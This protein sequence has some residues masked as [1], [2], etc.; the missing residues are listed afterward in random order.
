MRTT[1]AHKNPGGFAI[2]EM[3]SIYADS[4]L[5]RKYFRML[6]ALIL[7]GSHF[8]GAFAFEINQ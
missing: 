1:S 3:P 5:F 4:S 7:V 6:F 8:I 2:A